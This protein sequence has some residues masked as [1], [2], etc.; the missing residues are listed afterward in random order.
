[1]SIRITILTL[2]VIALALYAWKDWFKAVCGLVLLMAVVEHPDMPKNILGVQGLNPWNLLMADILLAWAL[3]R[4]REGLV[5]D[6]PRH[7]AV[8]LLLYFG[9]VL[10]SFLRLLA[11]PQRLEPYTAA[12]LGSEYIINCVK[13]VLPGLLLYDGC[14]TTGR[15]RLAVGCIVGLYLLLALQVIRYIPPSAAMSGS[16]VDHIAYKLVKN[17]IGYSRVNMSTLLSGA[18]WAMLAAVPLAKRRWQVLLAFAL[19]ALIAYAQALTGGRMGYI[20]WGLTGLLLCL[21][22][23][24]RLLLVA[25]LVP[26]VIA[27]ALPGVTERMLQGFGQTHVTGQTV[28]DDTLVTSD[29]TVA[30][31]YVVDRI[32]ESPALGYGREAMVR[33]GLRD[34]LAAIGQAFPHPHNAYLECLLDNGLVGFAPIIAFYLLVLVYATRLFLT[35]RDPWCATVGGLTCA[36]VLALLVAS[37]GS[38]TFY[39]REGS[40]GMW[41][42][43][44]LMFRVYVARAQALASLPRLVSVRP[45]RPTRRAVPNTSA[46]APSASS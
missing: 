30:W 36:L 12:G 27:V 41:A 43:I 5:W 21:L 16:D 6:L 42:A 24:R 23:W 25:P 29:R 32:M 18:S 33:T 38:Q 3:T 15:L 4:P 19:F 7:V 10:V 14:R 45:S 22:R 20:A 31:P 8:L 1:M 39:P 11:D 46:P 35:P 13:W 44:G 17:E 40:V 2:L 34:E 9:V 26:L 37:M 28:T